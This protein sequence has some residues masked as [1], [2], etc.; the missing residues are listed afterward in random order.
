MNELIDI[1]TGKQLN[2]T[3]VYSQ[4]V[5]RTIYWF[6]ESETFCTFKEFEGCQFIIKELQERNVI[7]VAACKLRTKNIVQFTFVELDPK[8]WVVPT[9]IPNLTC[10]HK[11][12]WYQFFNWDKVYHRSIYD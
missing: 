9:K 6:Y 10:P 7:C 11:K 8:R 5:R 2:L 4:R 3:F 12:K 1:H